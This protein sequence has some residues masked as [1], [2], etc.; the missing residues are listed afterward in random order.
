MAVDGSAWKNSLDY[1]GTAM[2]LSSVLNWKDQVLNVTTN[3]DFQG[4]PVLQNESWTMSA[5][6]KSFTQR[7]STVVNGEEYAATTFVFV[8][9]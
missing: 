9:K 1:M 5:D 7:V 4:T 2:Q 8:K 3:T 6:G